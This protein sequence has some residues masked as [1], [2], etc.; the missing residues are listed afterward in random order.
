MVLDFKHHLKWSS[1]CIL[2]VFLVMTILVVESQTLA[3]GAL[4][5]V[6]HFLLQSS[7]TCYFCDLT[8]IFETC[9]PIVSAC[10]SSANLHF[11]QK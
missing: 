7:L 1:L 5:N 9:V 8:L 2:I 4:C 10:F 6:V 3:S 11:F